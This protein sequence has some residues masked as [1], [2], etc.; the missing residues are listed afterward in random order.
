MSDNAQ[1]IKKEA[2][3]SVVQDAAHVEDIRV[4]IFKDIERIKQLQ[5][6]IRK[7][8]LPAGSLGEHERARLLRLAS[9][10]DWVEYFKFTFMNQK[11]FSHQNIVT[12]V[13]TYCS[14]ETAKEETIL[15][16]RI[17]HAGQTLEEAHAVM[18]AYIRNCMQEPEQAELAAWA[19]MHFMWQVKR[20]MDGREVAWH[21]CPVF[22]SKGQGTGKSEFVRNLCR[23][24]GLD[25]YSPFSVQ[26]TLPELSDDREL[27]ANLKR[28]IVFLDEMS[29]AKNA[30]WSKLKS[31]MTA[32]FLSPRMLGTNQQ[33]CVPNRATFIAT[34]NADSLSDKVRDETGNRRFFPILVKSFIEV[35]A[36][37]CSHDVIRQMI[38]DSTFLYPKTF[39]GSF[40]WR[41]INPDW[42]FF[43]PHD[44]ISKVQEAHRSQDAVENFVEA[45][46]IKGGDDADGG[47]WFESGILFTAFK[48]FAN[49]S[50]YARQQKQFTKRLG[51][52]LALKPEAKAGPRKKSSVNT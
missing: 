30:E 24:F 12:C 11:G 44:E 25:G 47:E 19:L 1:R 27:E 28:Y 35:P 33:T 20:K 48:K 38:G 13:T 16:Q 2:K 41:L 34:A 5:A 49:S 51:E 42:E 40:L 29:G 14:E 32:A 37:C 26:K 9:P 3:L 31:I 52:L 7:G 46:Q 43:L 6:T 50:L 39:D 23:P 15:R 36:F 22:M 45:L 18:T 21:L 10:S 4:V 17:A 8:E